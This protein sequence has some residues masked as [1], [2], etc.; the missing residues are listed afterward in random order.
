M[1]QLVEAFMKMVVWHMDSAE[2]ATKLHK[3]LQTSVMSVSMMIEDLCTMET[4]EAVIQVR[5][6]FEIELTENEIELLVT[7]MPHQPDAHVVRVANSC[8][9]E[10]G[11]NAIQQRR[12]LIAEDAA[13]DALSTAH[14]L[15]VAKLTLTAVVHRLIKFPAGVARA[16]EIDAMT[17]WKAGDVQRSVEA[18]RQSWTTAAT[19]STE[20]LAYAGVFEVPQA[21]TEVLISMTDEERVDA[22]LGGVREYVVSPNTTIDMIHLNNTYIVAPIAQE[23]KRRD[24]NKS[25]DSSRLLMLISCVSNDAEAERTLAIFFAAELSSGDWTTKHSGKYTRHTARIQLNV[26][27]PARL[28]GSFTLSGRVHV[29][30]RHW[31]LLRVNVVDDSPATKSL[32][33]KKASAVLRYFFPTAATSVLRQVAAI[34]IVASARVPRYKKDPWLFVVAVPK[35]YHDQMIALEKD[36]M[37]GGKIKIDTP[38]MRKQRHDDWVSRRHTTVPSQFDHNE[39]LDAIGDSGGEIAMPSSLSS[40]SSAPTTMGENIMPSSLSSLSSLSSSSS[41]ASA[42]MQK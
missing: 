7:Y 33:V 2:A 1:I 24:E 36:E 42:A 19:E 14:L 17:E 11:L 26:Q 9:V 40:S 15:V 35:R 34:A 38:E 12:A 5:N 21:L 20:P 16:L 8:T 41:A 39:A 23:D 29:S 28:G 22:L 27:T 3:L 31:T 18:I 13:A 6:T 4:G 25:A 32:D 10:F 30:A 37:T